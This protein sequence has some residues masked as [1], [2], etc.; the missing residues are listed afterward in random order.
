[1]RGSEAPV[2]TSPLAASAVPWQARMGEDASVRPL[3]LNLVHPVGSVRPI[4][5]GLAGD[6]ASGKSTLSVGIEYVLGTE[7]V[8]RLC[9]DDYHRWDRAERA[10]LGITPLVPEANRMDLMGEQLRALSEGRPSTSPCTTTRRAR[11]ASR[12]PSIRP[13][14]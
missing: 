1:M 4:L 12:C 7:R 5:L 6:S 2:T 10:E 8:A 11:S 9:T 3:E 14:S 13:R